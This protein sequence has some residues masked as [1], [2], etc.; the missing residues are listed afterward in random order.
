MK[1]MML[2]FNLLE[3]FTIFF[4]K[5]ESFMNKPKFSSRK[6]QKAVEISSKIEGHKI[7]RNATTAKRSKNKVKY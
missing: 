6:A 4:S 1:Y 7:P 3:K 2:K 5:K